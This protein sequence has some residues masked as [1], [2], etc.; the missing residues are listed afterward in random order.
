M[1]TTKQQVREFLDLLGFKYDEPEELDNLFLL[2]FTTQKYIY[3]SSDGD[4]NRVAVFIEVDEA[5]EMITFAAPQI[6]Q[7]PNDADKNNKLALFQSLLEIQYKYK[8]VRFT[9]DPSNGYIALKVSIPLEDTPLTHRMFNR[10]LKIIPEC[11]DEYH[12]DIIEALNEGLLPESEEAKRKALE[13]FQRQRRQQRRNQ[14]G[15]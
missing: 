5:G 1:S 15:D 14:F 9:Y 4:K 13:E 11:L 6:Y 10:C 7:C 8:L 12:S 2:F 3:K